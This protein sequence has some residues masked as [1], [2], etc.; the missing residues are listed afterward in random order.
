MIGD[1]GCCDG[2]S[3]PPVEE[4][5][6]NFTSEDGGDSSGRSGQISSAIPATM[7]IL[8]WTEI[9]GGNFF[10][11]GLEAAELSYWV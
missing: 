9:S 1:V 2:G 3:F 4:L 7:R 6:D 10:E 8:F 11:A 5:F